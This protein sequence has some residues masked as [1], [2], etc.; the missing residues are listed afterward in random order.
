MSVSLPLD[1]LADI[2]QLALSLLWTPH[3]TVHRVIS[4]LGKAKFCTN[5][6][7]QL[8][9]LHCLI[10]SDMLQVYYSPTHLFS[11]VF[12]LSSLYQLEQLSHLQQSPV[13]LQFL[14]PDVVIAT[15]AMPT[16]FGLLFSEIWSTFIS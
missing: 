9:S 14:L 15:D 16:H 1:K 12:S 5:G 10:Q 6:H 7:S 3:V 11:H 8:W 4:F 2:Q 13:P